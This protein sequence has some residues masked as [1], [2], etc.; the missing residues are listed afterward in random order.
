MNRRKFL[1]S[2]VGAAAALSFVPA[3]FSAEQIFTGLMPGIAVGGYD[4]V[5]FFTQD[6]AV[7]GDKGFATQ[8]KDAQ[9]LFASQMNLDMFLANP[10]K[11]APQYGGYCA[12]AA[13][14]G[15]LAK[16]DPEAWT[17][18]ED[19]LYLNFS[20]SVRK[21]WREDISGHIKS[22]DANFPKLIETWPDVTSW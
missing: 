11:Y 1:L 7:V 9:W 2:S 13:S 14:K 18:H 16:G 15:A 12:F 22:A 21:L 10:E 5:A 4:T 3:A 8:Y 6:A 17:I 19:K 20:K